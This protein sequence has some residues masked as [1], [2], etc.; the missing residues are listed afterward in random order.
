MEVDISGMDFEKQG[1]SRPRPVARQIPVFVIQNCSGS[2]VLS[3]ASAQ[4]EESDGG[5]QNNA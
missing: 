2:F 3:D 5:V 1:Y 4:M